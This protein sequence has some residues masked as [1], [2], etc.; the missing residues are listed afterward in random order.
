MSVTPTLLA[1]R[2]RLTIACV[3][4]VLLSSCA[5]APIWFPDDSIRPSRPADALLNKGAGRGDNLFVTLRLETGEELL[6]LVDTGSPCT[7]LDKSLDAKLGKRLGTQKV[8]WLGGKGGGKGRA[9]VYKAPK[10]YLYG[11]ELVTAPR[12]LTLD[13][14]PLPLLPGRPVRGILGTDCLRHYCVRLDFESGKMRFLDP[15]HPE[16]ENPGNA[17]PLRIF[18]GSIFIPENLVGV[19][20]E[21]SKMDTG[22]TFDG[23]LK[24]RLWQ[25][26]LREQT[27][28]ETNAA[29]VFSKGIWGGETYTNLMLS[30]YGGFPGGHNLVGLRFLAR[31]KVTFN[32]PKRTMYLQ[33][34]SVGPLAVERSSTNVLGSTRGWWETEGS[35]ALGNDKE[36][37]AARILSA[38]N[39]RPAGPDAF[40]QVF[41]WDPARF[42]SVGAPETK[43]RFVHLPPG[44]CR[45]KVVSK[46]ER[47]EDGGGGLMFEG[48]PETNALPMVPVQ[49]RGTVLLL[50][51]YNY[52]KEHMIL[53]TWLLAQDGYRVVLV[54][55][56][57]NGESSGPTISYGKYETADIS[58]VL[59]RLTEQRL[60]DG[61]VGVL[62]VGYGANLALH[63]AARDPRVRTVVAIAPYNQPEQ[64]FERTAREHQSSISPEVLQD[65]LALVAARVDIKW[66][67]WSGEAALRQMKQ[68][69]LLIGG[70]EDTICTTNDLKVLEQAA[71]SGSKSLLIAEANRWAV[72]YWF[73]EISEPVI[74]WFQEHLPTRSEVQSV[75]H[76]TTSQLR[77]K[78]SP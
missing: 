70:G 7:F 20:G 77:P 5:T 25:R 72:R 64:A 40:S 2:V 28:F 56:R 41:S 76:K 52:Q 6:F 1:P 71:P 4:L 39:L 16:D 62:G 21:K 3:C 24:P 30:Q 13:L 44:V 61:T 66:A 54:D 22:C 73:H 53:W 11:T 18:F 67:D 33:R 69:V 57:G 50:H 42:I 17:F 29:G 38:P 43:L 60:C 8:K 27:T 10:L 49:E 15:D 45:M 55:L 37:L 23:T 36:S 9:S 74:T 34:T 12:V 46:A 75:D 14:T 58:Q 51:D 32:F 26:K 48:V 59:D 35:S 47:E 68:P 31:H 63:W 65:A 19:K 78:S